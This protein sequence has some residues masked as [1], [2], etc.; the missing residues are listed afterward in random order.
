MT[1][2]GR[3]AISGGAVEASG[4]SGGGHGIMSD[5]GVIDITGGAVTAKGGSGETGGAGIFTMDDNV[6]ISGGTVEAVGGDGSTQ[7]GAAIRSGDSVAIRSGTVTATGGTGGS[8]GAGID[9]MNED[10]GIGISG[11]MV[12]TGG[13]TGDFY[14]TDAGQAVIVCD[15]IE[16][17]GEYEDEEF[18]SGLICQGGELHVYGSQILTKAVA[19]RLR[20]DGLYVEDEGSLTIEEDVE[21]TLTQPSEV[22]GTGSLTNRGVIRNK[23]TL[24]N[25]NL[26]VND[27]TIYNDG[28]LHAHKPVTGSGRIIG[29]APLRPHVL[30]VE[31]MTFSAEVGY[32]P[33][34]QA[35]T[36]RNAGFSD[37]YFTDVTVDGEDFE[38]IEGKAPVKVE[39][40]EA[41][42]TWRIK[43]RAG[44]PAGT[45]TALITVVYTG[46][47]EDQA[48]G[49][50]TFTVRAG[51]ADKD[52]EKP[53][54][55]RQDKAP[56][57]G[58]GTDLA[59]YAGALLVSAGALARVLAGRKKRRS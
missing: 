32:A 40:G 23:S 34:E 27:G 28:T 11:G 59:L 55:G 37:S 10:G 12:V 33:A 4:G 15:K 21:L 50:V 57:T 45:Y 13:I 1:G 9:A 56:P 31:D 8:G 3:I 18:W 7:G 5:N 58:D 29:D 54:G 53:A 39:T 52:K 26:L 38:L 17:T 46:S 24:C 42:T 47:D 43:P 20:P 16:D 22:A 2:S 6:T 35:V 41:D 25:H 14:T 51:A 36:V 44:L 30:R 49:R 48:T 19:D